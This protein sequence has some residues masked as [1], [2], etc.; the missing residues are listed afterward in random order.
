M[1]Y[2]VDYLQNKNAKGKDGRPYQEHE[3]LHIDDFQ[4]WCSSMHRN[5]PSEGFTT[6]EAC[7]DARRYF[8]M[9]ADPLFNLAVTATKANRDK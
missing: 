4:R 1:S 2:R 8:I 7:D 5:Y 3:W 9:D 6:Q